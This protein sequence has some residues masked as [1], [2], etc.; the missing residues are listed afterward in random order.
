MSRP[1][2]TMY[3]YPAR[4]IAQPESGANV[5]NNV[6][7]FDSGNNP[8]SPAPPTGS[9]PF[10]NEYGYQI[11]VIGNPI[12]QGPNANIGSQGQAFT[13]PGTGYLLDVNGN[14]ISATP[15]TVAAPATPSTST[16][17]SPSSPAPST[18]GP[19]T[20]TSPTPDTSGGTPPSSGSPGSSPASTWAS[21]TPAQRA[22]T[23]SK[24]AG[25]RRAR[26]F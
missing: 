8:L 26:G 3:V 1:K 12:L 24:M 16:P 10:Y 22:V 17:T 20:G 11:D 21:M 4:Q 14:M 6:A 5:A 18:T 2:G 15:A 9:G 23:M 7:F 25:S 13:Q 19:T